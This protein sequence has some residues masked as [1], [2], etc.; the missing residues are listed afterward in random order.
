MN[1][2]EMGIWLAIAGLAATP[3]WF[4][5]QRPNAFL[6]MKGCWALVALGVL[7]IAVPKLPVFSGFFKTNAERAFE[8]AQIDVREIKVLRD[9]FESN[10][11]VIKHSVHEAQMFQQMNADIQSQKKQLE[12]RIIQW[13]T[14]TS[15]ADAWLER[16][17]EKNRIFSLADQALVEGSRSAYEELYKSLGKNE[18][19][20]TRVAIISQILK[21]KA[22]YLTGNRFRNIEITVPG[23]DKKTLKNEQIPQNELIALL[24]HNEQWPARAKVVELLGNYK[25]LESAQT[26]IKVIREDSQMDVV[27]SAIQSFQ[28]ITGFQS[29]DTFPIDEAQSWWQKN[30]AALSLA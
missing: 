18:D 14:K 28:R 26:L 8:Q 22:F 13:E 2:E 15:Q 24:N 9:E 12:D 29:G 10:L 27:R 1:L 30:Q 16:I 17:E 6:I 3:W 5:S 7:C 4:R 19:E 25:T 11:K 23:P 21:I 20:T